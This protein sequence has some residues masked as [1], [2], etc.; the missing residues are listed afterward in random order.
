MKCVVCGSK[1]RRKDGSEYCS[2][3]CERN[4]SG[5]RPVKKPEPDRITDDLKWMGR[6][7]NV[8]RKKRKCR[9][10]K[11]FYIGMNEVQ[12]PE[13]WYKYTRGSGSGTEIVDPDF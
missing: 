6:G 2:R 8:E 10:C 3:K 5:E 11:K 13:C 7:F 1:I 9:R 12:C 4:K